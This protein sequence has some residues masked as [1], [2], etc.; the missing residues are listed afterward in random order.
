MPRPTVLAS[1]AGA[2][3][4]ASEPAFAH[5]FAGPHMFI[6]TLMIDDPNVADEA[7]LANVL[8]SAA[9]QR[10]RTGVRALRAAIRVRQA[11]H[12]EL[13]LLDLMAA[14]SGCTPPGQKTAKRL[15]ELGAGTLKYKIYVN[16]EHEFMLSLGV[17]ARVRAHRRDRRER[18]DTR[19]RSTAVPR[20]R[21]SSGARASATCRSACCARSRSP[22]RSATRSPTRS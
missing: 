11:H 9:A 19:H 20:R 18:R 16:A 7:S 2:S 1:L 5:G 17:F 6:S 10:W 15:G 8:L 21:R 3:L 14:I 22:E 4:L 12:R 13:R